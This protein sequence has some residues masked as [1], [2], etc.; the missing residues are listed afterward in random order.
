VWSRYDTIF[1]KVA[2]RVWPRFYAFNSANVELWEGFLRAQRPWESPQLRW[3]RT[4]LGWHLQG[5]VLPCWQPPRGATGP[6][7]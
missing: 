6:D 4:P 2:L 7:G 3:V 5:D 1:N